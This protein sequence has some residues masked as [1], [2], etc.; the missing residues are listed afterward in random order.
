M[1]T[2]L[3]AELAK[4]KPRTTLCPGKLSRMVGSTLRE[5]RPT[6]EDMARAGEIQF[7]QRGVRVAPAGLR[8]PF[9]VA[10]K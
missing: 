8:G 9:R 6:L 3:L 5:M 4:L 2:R 1:R 10:I 7:Y